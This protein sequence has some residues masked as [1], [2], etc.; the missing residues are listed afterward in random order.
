MKIVHIGATGTLGSAVVTE[1]APRHEIIQV[2]HQRGQLQVDITNSDSIKT[3][4]E[5]IGKVDA[6][7][8]T[9]GNLHFGPLTQMTA[10]QFRIG[11][12][13]KLLGQVDL[14]LI[15]QHYLN[16]AGS[17][18]LTSGIVANQPIRLGANASAVN[19]A[20]EGF[21]LGAAIEL[22]RGIRINV[23]SPT[24]L[25]ESMGIYGDFFAGFEAVPARRAALAFRRSV[26]GAQTGQ[27]YQVV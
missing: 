13:S 12:N 16:D 6:I 26:E 3:L 19:S 14:A 10:E 7:I 22:A 9:T 2:G 21:V 11:L 18:T 5:R 17:I 25:E 8:A 24:I 4:F 20:I 27:V 23:V 15:G 1:L